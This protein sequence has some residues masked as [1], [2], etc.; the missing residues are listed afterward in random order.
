MQMH[1]SATKKL[2]Y[3]GMS[4]HVSCSMIEL[5][6]GADLHSPSNSRREADTSHMSLRGLTARGGASCSAELASCQGRPRAGDSVST[7]HQAMCASS[8]Q[9]RDKSTWRHKLLQQSYPCSSSIFCTPQTTLSLCLCAMI[10]CKWKGIPSS[11]LA[12]K[13]TV[14]S[15]GTPAVAGQGDTKPSMHHLDADG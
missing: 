5:N 7:G 3:H 6:S 14:K 12:R 1:S 11:S 15:A 10:F 4:A 2:I 8:A 13:G 9:K